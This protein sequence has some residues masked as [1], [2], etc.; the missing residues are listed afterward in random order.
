MLIDGLNFDGGKLIAYVGRSRFTQKILEAEVVDKLGEKFSLGKVFASAVETIKKKIFRRRLNVRCKGLKK[1]CQLNLKTLQTSTTN[2]FISV[3]SWRQKV[4][5]PSTCRLSQSVP[6]AACSKIFSAIG[7]RIETSL[8]FTETN[9]TISAIS[10]GCLLFKIFAQ[11]AANF[12]K[13]RQTCLD[14]FVSVVG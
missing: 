3:A 2:T 11:D 9:R 8:N 4:S 10:I 13:R 1:F 7:R 14:F 6:C 5:H 12:F